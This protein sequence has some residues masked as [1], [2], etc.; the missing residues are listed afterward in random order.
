MKCVIKEN[1][2]QNK[3]PCNLSIA[4]RRCNKELS[5]EVVAFFHFLPR[6][7]LAVHSPPRK[8]NVGEHERNKQ[9][10]EAHHFE[11]E[12]ARRTVVYRQ[13]TLHIDRR[14]IVGRVVVARDEEDAEHHQYGA[15]AAVPDAAR[16]CGRQ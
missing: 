4:G 11:R 3:P 2:Y 8:E 14:R 15:D 5:I 12:E 13:R 10:Y 6:D 7:G 16:P 1:F 9:R